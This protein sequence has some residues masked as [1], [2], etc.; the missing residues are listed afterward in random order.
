MEPLWSQF[1][2]WYGLVAPFWSQTPSMASKLMP[3]WLPLHLFPLGEVVLVGVFQNFSNPLPQLSEPKNET[4]SESFSR[5]VL[6]P[7][8]H[9]FEQKTEALFQKKISHFSTA[10][11]W[12]ENGHA[13]QKSFL[14]SVPQVFLSESQHWKGTIFYSYTAA[15]ILKI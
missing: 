2:F 3:F 5:N 12:S 10:R 4:F 13:F 7:L 14:K 9:V 11:F 15:F 6:T 1:S 8:P